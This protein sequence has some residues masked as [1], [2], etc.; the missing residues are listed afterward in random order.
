MVSMIAEPPT[1]VG[2]CMPTIV[3]IGMRA[4]LT[5]WRMIVA[6]YLEALRTGS[7]DIVL[8]QHL[9]H[10]GQR[11]PHHA[12]GQGCPENDAGNDENRRRFISGSSS[13]EMYCSGGAQPHQIVGKIMTMMPSQKL[14][15]A[16]PMT[17]MVRPA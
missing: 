5:A 12:C 15:V 7:P 8:R 10:H 13:R 6:G 3:P 9:Q 14:G 2:N 1:G 11:H 16:M 4:F 17:A